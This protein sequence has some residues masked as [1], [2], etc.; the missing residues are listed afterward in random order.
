[1]DPQSATSNPSSPVPLLFTQVCIRGWVTIN[2]RWQQEAV[3]PQIGALHWNRLFVEVN[4]SVPP[5]VLDTL[6]SYSRR[7]SRQPMVN[8]EQQ[9]RQHDGYGFNFPQFFENFQLKC[10]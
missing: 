7:D 4:L 1:M 8:S 9:G 3:S 6:Q 2:T 10:E 5:L